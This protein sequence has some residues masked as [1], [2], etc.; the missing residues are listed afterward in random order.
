MSALV[1][2]LVGC[3]LAGLAF[4][5]LLASRDAD[6]AASRATQ[7][8]RGFLGA[9]ATLILLEAMLGVAGALT[10]TATAT[11]L[12][13]IGL[14]AGVAARRRA[15]PTAGQAR[16]SWHPQDTVLCAALLAL[17]AMR[18]WN[19]T[20]RGSYF[21]DA[22]SYHLHVPVTW[23]HHHRL[24]IV[25]A[26]FGDPAPA[27]APG[28]M[29]LAFLFLMAPLRSDYLAGV[30]QLPFAGLAALA[31][32]AAVREAGGR[33]DAGLAAALVFLLVPEVHG[34]IASAM[35]DLG[36][37]ALLLASLPFVHRLRRVH[38][39]GD[40]ARASDLVT[41]ALALGLAIGTKSVGLV[42]ALPFAIAAAVF[43]VRA[44]RVGGTAWV[45]AGAALVAGG[46]FWY[47]RN[48]FLT[49]NP[50]YPIS[51]LG[52][53][54]LYDAAAMRA[55]EYHLPVADLGA[56]GLMLRDAGIA[57]VLAA[58]IAI[59]AA[60]IVR[61]AALE[62]VLAVA[63][64]A[65]FWLVVPYQESRFL[66]STFGLAVIAMARLASPPGQRF[67]EPPKPAPARA[68]P[69]VLAGA[70]ALAVVVALS[71]G[72][73]AYA[74][75]D[76]GYTVGDDLEDAWRW[77]RANV[78]GE[79]VAYTGNNLAFPLAGV[80]LAN[81]VSYVNVAGA[82]A[83]RLHDF[84][85]RPTASA[86]PAPYR[87]GAD[88]ATWTR[89]LRA[90]RVSTLFVAAMYPIVRRTIAADAD[91]FPVERAWADAH[92]DL[93]RLRYDSPAA[94]VYAVAPAAG[95]PP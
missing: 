91:G 17:L 78:R 52:L 51:A 7:L 63:S 50:V 18:F 27:Y 24:Q 42:L 72:A 41:A 47:V 16:E 21:Y 6:R 57:F 22:L 71:F 55:W 20:H 85:A 25:P 48:A 5:R 83:A 46:G 10:T 15:K 26:V 38:P 94:R 90:A 92:P 67:P 73:R 66:F 13:A 2:G 49:G 29:E 1:G 62:P 3:A 36:L 33:R 82:P 64:L 37:A 12:L 79:R 19:G 74:A 58:L 87:D 23:M 9:F 81:E 65:L 28:N 39:P 8:V 54:G 32:V 14:A 80:G 11:A 95:A 76:P 77:F 45:A 59:V 86:E 93:F 56:L 43:A 44:P 31:I 61:R 30:G 69:L 34:Q 53:R 88:F 60:P 68:I 84:P 70:A 4:A 40:A 75:R 89:T 35:A